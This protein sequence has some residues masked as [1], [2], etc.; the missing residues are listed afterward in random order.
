MSRIARQAVHAPKRRMELL[1]YRF[2]MPV[3]EMVIYQNK[4]SYYLCPRCL[5]TL[6]REFSAYCDRCGQ[7]LSW[8]RYKIAKRFYV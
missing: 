7:C 1:S 6:D 2:P 3:T 5:I 8:R 4:H